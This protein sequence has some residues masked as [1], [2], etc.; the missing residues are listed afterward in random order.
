[1][2]NY[3]LLVICMLPIM[4]AF[5][6][7]DA[8]DVYIADYDGKPGSTVLNMS[9]ND[10]APIK[11]MPFLVVTGLNPKETDDMGFP[12]KDQYEVQYPFTDSLDVLVDRLVT[13]EMV[14]IFTSDGERIH[15]IYV[16]DT[17]NLRNA[18]THFY[19]AKYP[20][21][22]YYL[23]VRPDVEWKAYLDFLYPNEF[24]KEYMGNEKVIMQLKDSGD[25]LDKERPVDFWA[26]FK[27]DADRSKYIDFV[28]DN[29]FEIVKEDK[30]DKLD[31]PYSI[32]FTKIMAINIMDFT[33]VT[34]E[35]KKKATELRGDYDGWESIVVK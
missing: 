24:T 33:N 30:D 1:M 15:Y 32:Q 2:K 5:A 22:T 28:T 10:R 14:G 23:N 27:T 35:L 4:S 20:T 9:I 17:I 29:G 12:T 8:W 25:K 11:T 21:Y 3:A 26:F 31:L 34:L 19:K 13:S 16:Q 18:L 7:E 6:Q